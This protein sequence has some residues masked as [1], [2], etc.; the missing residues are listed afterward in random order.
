MKRLSL[1]FLVLAGCASVR[2]P[3]PAPPIAVLPGRGEEQPVLPLRAEAEQEAVLERRAV[4]PQKLPPPIVNH[5]TTGRGPASIG[6]AESPVKIGLEDSLPVLMVCSGGANV[7]NVFSFSGEPEKLRVFFGL[8][9]GSTVAGTAMISLRAK[10]S[11]PVFE[12]PVPV[13][14][15][16][17]SDGRRYSLAGTVG[18]SH[19][20]MELVYNG[21]GTLYRS[22]DNEK[23]ERY[24]AHCQVEPQNR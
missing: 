3:D 11:T 10:G 13:T 22:V 2:E 16:R 6:P 19:F 7:P 9:G 24:E 23:A 20:S 17:T 12:G 4:I 5:R 18:T 1:L 14:G 15:T 8:K 21:T